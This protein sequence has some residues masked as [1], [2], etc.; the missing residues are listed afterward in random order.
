MAPRGGNSDV[1]ADYTVDPVAESD[2]PAIRSLIEAAIRDSVAASEEEAQFLIE[3]IG[4]SLDGWREHPQDALHLKAFSPEGVL[5]VILVKEY[6][7][8]TNLFVK[9]AYQGKGIGRCLVEKALNEC[10]RRSPRGAVLVN[11]STVAVPFYRRLGF[12][13]TGPGKDRPG[14]CV[15]F[16]YAFPALPPG[17][18]PT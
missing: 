17:G 6:W 1:T 8:L 11:S 18:R 16:Q 12:S 2:L 14:G 10:R 15:P 9:P 7:N 4:H 13:Q 5:G 3:D